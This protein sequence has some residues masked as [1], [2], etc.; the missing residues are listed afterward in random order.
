[1]LDAA[2]RAMQAETPKLVAAEAE[3]QNQSAALDR[4]IAA[5]RAQQKLAEGEA[6]DAA[7]RA[8]TRH[9]E[10]TPARRAG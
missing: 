8:A 3:Q 10:L 1:M 7:Q 4:Q 9:R 6:T 5:A 2:T